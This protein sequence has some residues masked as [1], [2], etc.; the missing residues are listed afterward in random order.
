MEVNIED[1]DAA[2]PVPETRHRD[3]PSVHAAQRLMLT[4]ERASRNAEH[5][6]R[7]AANPAYGVP[8]PKAASHV[9]YDSLPD[10]LRYWSFA[11]SALVR[12]LESSVRLIVRAPSANKRGRLPSLKLTHTPIQ[13]HLRNSP[14]DE[15]INVRIILNES[16]GGPKPSR[17]ASLRVVGATETDHARLLGLAQV[18]R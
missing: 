8:A 18:R 6:E 4:T 10:G 15:V 16:R 11:P 13:L 12:G 5:P 17:K 14:I 1:V 3:S 7:R 9:F 2:P